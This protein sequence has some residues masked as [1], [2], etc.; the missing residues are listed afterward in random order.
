LLR[1]PVEEVA[2][3]PPGGLARQ[4]ERFPDEAVIEPLPQATL[5]HA[6]GQIP[7]RIRHR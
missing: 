6:A 3:R 4:R 5:R 1:E 2:C 7:R